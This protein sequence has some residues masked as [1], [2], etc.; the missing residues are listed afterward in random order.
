NRRS[1]SQERDAE[2]RAVAAQLLALC[3]GVVW[4]GQNVGDMNDFALKQH[5]PGYRSGVESKRV[6]C[7]ELA[8]FT[9][10][11]VARFEVVS[12]ALRATYDHHLGL[13]QPRCRLD[14]C[15]E[16]GL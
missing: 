2:D 11:P 3:P 10:E 1:F 7:G 16:H 6:T 13:A 5:A 9:R 12:F 8:E 15:V 4:V 14:Q